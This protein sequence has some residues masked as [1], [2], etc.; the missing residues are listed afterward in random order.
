MIIV[1]GGTGLVGGHLLLR[2]AESDQP[3]R[4][5]IRPGGNPRKVL[6][7]WKHY[8][9]NPEDLLARFD[10]H[11]TDLLNRAD[12]YEALEGAD[13]IYHCAAKV[14]FDSR[15]KKAMWKTNVLATKMIVDYC[16]AN[17]IRKLIYISS[18]AAVAKS[19]NGEEAEEKNGWP[20]NPKSIY[21]KTKTL[22]E[23][24]IWRGIAEGLDAVI[25]NPSVILGPGNWDTG[26]ARIVKEISKGLRFYTNGAT[27]Y[28]DV[29]DV[30]DIILRL[31]KSNISGE[32][33]ILNSAN[34]AF[35]DL[36]ERIS[37]ELNKR[38][39]SVCISPFFTS[40]LCKAEWIVSRITG[41]E[42]RMSRETRIAAHSQQSYSARKIQ[43]EFDYTFRDIG[44]TIQHTVSCFLNQ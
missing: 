38:P 31:M 35:R 17:T 2:L 18:V 9:Q 8:L 19:M 25:V 4:V 5:L 34:L 21:A 12:L 33:Y 11:D 29:R 36:F 7:V 44:T 26:S 16:I 42:A 22:A 1:T 20:V 23:H 43:T 27:G 41:K 15:N 3:V 14:S 13:Y 40:L 10:W 37:R 32:R 30:A 6:S 24:E 28:V 39:P